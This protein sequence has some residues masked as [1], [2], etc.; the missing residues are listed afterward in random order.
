MVHGVKSTANPSSGHTATT[1]YSIT[2]DSSGGGGG[3]AGVPAPVAP[4][5]TIVKKGKTATLKCQINGQTTGVTTA[6]ATI[7]IKNAAGKVVKTIKTTAKPVN[8]LQTATFKCTLA[9]G[10]YTF[11]VSA[12]DSGGTAST[13]TATNKLTVKWDDA[14]AQERD[15]AGCAGPVAFRAPELAADCAPV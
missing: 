15:G 14:T 9:K 4:S 12:V 7:Q 10:K 3:G 2:V 6:T 11:T 8:A 5:A 13:T 1:T